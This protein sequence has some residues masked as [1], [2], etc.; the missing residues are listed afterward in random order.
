MRPDMHDHDTDSP[1]PRPD[2]QS[3]Q[4][5]NPADGFDQEIESLQL[6]I[7]QLEEDKAELNQDKLRTIADYQNF[8][9]RAAAN[10]REAKT[11]GTT[12]IVLNI[13]PILD[14]FDLALGQDLSKVNADQIAAGVR[15]IRDELVRVL[16]KHGVTMIEPAPGDEFDPHRH[17]AVTQMDDENIAPGHI[18]RSLQ[19]GYALSERVIRPASVSVRPTE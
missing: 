13:L 6:R 3:G 16:Q 12:A 8:A 17:Q 15:V 18:V 19:N 7:A 2:D 14:N 1:E 10:E 4:G 11:Q 9:K 5:P